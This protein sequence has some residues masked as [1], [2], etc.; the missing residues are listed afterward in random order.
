ML[1]AQ[2]KT[3]LM[4]MDLHALTRRYGTAE[5]AK[6]LGVTERCLVDLRRGRSPLTVDDLHQLSR[7]FPGFDLPGTVERIATVR[8]ARGWSR[9][10]RG[11]Q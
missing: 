2:R 3:D 7:A 1:R 9:L 5:V 6:E 11:E 4:S 8:D 10:R